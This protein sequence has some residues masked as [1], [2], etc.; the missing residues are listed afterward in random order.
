MVIG[1]QINE[2]V[3]YISIIGRCVIWKKSDT[4]IKITEYPIRDPTRKFYAFNQ[5]VNICYDNDDGYFFRIKLNDKDFVECKG[6]TIRTNTN[7]P[8]N[9]IKINFDNIKEL[10]SKSDFDELNSLWNS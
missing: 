2:D 10:L 3:G 4:S 5:E 8:V 1:L 9:Y 7:I 6:C